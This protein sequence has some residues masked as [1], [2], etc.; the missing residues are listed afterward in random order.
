[1]YYIHFIG[2]LY[3]EVNKLRFRTIIDICILLICSTITYTL[4]YSLF[5]YVFSL[6]YT[7]KSEWYDIVSKS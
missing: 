4:Y 5:I 6:Y 1:M 3:N 7:I 2:V